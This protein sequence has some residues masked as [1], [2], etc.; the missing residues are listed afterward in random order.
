MHRRCG[1]SLSTRERA[2]GS[3]PHHCVL[4]CARDDTLFDLSRVNE[5]AVPLPCHHV[6]PFRRKRKAPPVIPRAVQHEVVHRRCGTSLSIARTSSRVCTAP[7]RA[8]AR[9]DDTL[10]DLSRFNEEAVPLPCHH[11]GLSPQAKS[12]ACHPARR[13]TKWCTADAG[14]R[15][16]ATKR[17]SGSAPHHFVL[18]QRRDDTLFDLSQVNEEACFFLA[19]HPA[20]FASE[21]RPVIAC[22]S[23]RENAGKLCCR[24]AS[25]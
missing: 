21:L 22:C 5:E 1:T 19:K 8:A 4:R 18:R 16:N 11:V 3:A 20:H 17:R 9:R 14:P 24:S 2:P 23:P 15:S 25:S 13:S 10:F 12:S 6:G 7:L